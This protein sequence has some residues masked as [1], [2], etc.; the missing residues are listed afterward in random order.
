MEHRERNGWIIGLV[1]ILVGGVLL[2]QQ[3]GFAMLVG[4]WWA[5]FI[6]I[7]ALAAFSAAWRVYQQDGQFTPRV[8][9][10]VTGGLVPLTIALVFLLDVNFGSAWP[11]LLVVVG[12]GMLLRATAAR[13][14]ETPS[15]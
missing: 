14:G 8:V 4:N 6:L 10:L 7:P 11:L 5:V 2:L 15:S 1:L 3:A 13:P 12:A 9:G